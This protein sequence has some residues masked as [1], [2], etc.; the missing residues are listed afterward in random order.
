LQ[1]KAESAKVE[2]ASAADKKPAA[3]PATPDKKEGNC[4]L[5]VV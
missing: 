3:D 5:C 2:A 4:K 1:T